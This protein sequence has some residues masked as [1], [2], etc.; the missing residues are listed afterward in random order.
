[1]PFGARGPPGGGGQAG[2][3]AE[4][5]WGLPVITRCWFTAALAS[6]LLA[7]VG[8][9]SPGTLYLDWA[10]VVYKFQI[11]RLF[12][13]FAFLGKFGWPFIMNLIFMVQ[14]SKTLEQDFK[15]VAADF[16]W[17]LL[18]GGSL[19][20]FINHVSGLALPFLTIPL[21]FMTIWIWSRIHP[22]A[23]M[24][25]F[26]LFSISSAHFP[27]FLICLTMLMGGSPVANLMGY[28][29]GHVYWFLKH[30]FQPTAG[31]AF[32]SAPSVIRRLVEDEEVHT[33]ATAGGAV[34]F[35]VSPYWHS[36]G[37]CEV[38]YWH[39]VWCHALA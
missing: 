31:H 24:S 35:G 17:L 21:I 14:Y 12:T 32:F 27:W 39:S 19:L 33:T 37:C 11:W 2:S 29:V 3:P 23:Q 13:N 10:S 7:A 20:M 25:V 6:T 28:F 15:G 38:R 1:M 9:L 30:V 36:V 18:L 5:Y 16:L 22:N 8:M 4:F 34:R 26:G